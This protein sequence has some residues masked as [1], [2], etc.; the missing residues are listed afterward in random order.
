[1][2]G[3]D[4]CPAVSWGIGMDRRKQTKLRIFWTGACL[5]LTG[6]LAA[7]AVNMVTLYAYVTYSIYDS[8]N[9]PLSNGSY[10]YIIGSGDNVVDPM[11]TWGAPA[12]N[13]IA[14]GTTGDDVFLGS[15]TIG[16]GTGSNGTFFVSIEYDSDLINYVYLRFF[17]Y[18]GPGNVTG[19]VYWGNSSN[20]YVGDPEFGVKI[21]DFNDGAP[22]S[23]VAS[24][25]NN[26]VVIPEPGTANLIVLVAGMAWVMRTS[27]RKSNAK[28]TTGKGTEDSRA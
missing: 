25:Y 6:M 7:Y 17:D 9:N 8:L 10:V 28:K 3:R 26:F 4:V 5:V 12:T 27:L 14:E 20:F 23:L 13:Y 15:V 19:M 24:N 1:M 18:Q 2:N 22:N 21:Q 16:T 11:P